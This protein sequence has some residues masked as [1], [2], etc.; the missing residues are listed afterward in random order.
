MHGSVVAGRW[1]STS[2]F[3]VRIYREALL[4]V[5]SA[6]NHS[7][8]MTYVWRLELQGGQRFDSRIC[9]DVLS[10]QVL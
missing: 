1:T 2:A 7:I 10:A 6:R 8:A 9:C 3:G 4:E 5:Q